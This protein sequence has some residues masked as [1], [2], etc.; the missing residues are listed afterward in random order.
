[1]YH[2][3]RVKYGMKECLKK[4]KNVLM[5]LL[6]DTLKIGRAILII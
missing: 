5:I 1:V 6:D 3:C 2:L 4:L